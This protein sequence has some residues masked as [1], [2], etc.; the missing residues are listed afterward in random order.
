MDFELP[1]V[2]EQSFP[3]ARVPHD[4]CECSRRIKSGNNYQLVKGLWDGRWEVFK[5]CLRCLELRN[6]IEVRCGEPI[7]FTTLKNCLYQEFYNGGLRRELRA[8]REYNRQGAL[9][10]DG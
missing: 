6:L 10:G 3:R 8:Y 7:A 5:T 1:E 2:Y 9:T 4:C